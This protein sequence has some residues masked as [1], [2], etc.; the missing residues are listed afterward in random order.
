MD[1]GTNLTEFVGHFDPVMSGDMA[2]GLM[3]LALALIL[4][5]IFVAF[6]WIYVDSLFPLQSSVNQI[7]FQGIAAPPNTPNKKQ[8]VDIWK[9]KLI[10]VNIVRLRKNIVN[11]LSR[12]SYWRMADFIWIFT[13]DVNC[14]YVNGHYKKLC[15]IL[16]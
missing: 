9:K 13:W 5:C 10:H 6:Y 3:I 12:Y 8:C 14:G 1:S 2:C 16:T 4:M 7:N 15:S 11:F